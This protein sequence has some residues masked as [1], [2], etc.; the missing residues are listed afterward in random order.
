M[1]QIV[2]LISF[3]VFSST[4][5]SQKKISESVTY[6]DISTPLQPLDESV[7]TYSVIVTT[8]YELTSEDIQKESLAAFEE[9]QASFDELIRQSELEFQE[10][11]VN[12][13]RDVQEAKDLYDKRIKDFKELSL[14]ERLSLTE[15]GKKP[16]LRVPRRP[17]YVEPREPEYSEPNLNDYLIFDEK[18]MADQVELLGYEKAEGGLLI[19]INFT[20]MNFQ[21]NGGQTNYSQPTTLTLTANGAVIHKKVFNEESNFLTR[22]SSNRINLSSYEKQNVLKLMNEI[23]VYL[24][25]QFGYKLISTS[26]AIAYPKNKKR[27][28]D[29]LEKAKV[30]AISSYRKLNE[31]AAIDDREIAKKGLIDV[32]NMWREELKRIDYQDSKADMNNEVAKMIFF[33]I[34]KVDLSLKDKVASEKTF[35]EIQD[36]IIDLDLSDSEERVLANLEKKIYKL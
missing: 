25:D 18:S 13:D 8:P 6:Y 29:A 10:K 33:N 36:L 22:S 23:E 4:L 14:L 5:F 2:L 21:Q 31:T 12:H 19:E 20:K 27:L 16:E 1:K 24:N 34:L 17:V 26:I 7:K 32:Q 30:K 9:E 11:L 3:L 28:Y 15:Q 35:T